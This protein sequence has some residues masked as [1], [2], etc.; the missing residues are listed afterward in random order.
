MEILTTY[1]V[2]LLL[3]GI[4]IGCGILGFFS[5]FT[6]KF[7]S[8]ASWAL[9]S[10]LASHIYPYLKPWVS[11]FISNPIGATATTLISVFLVLLV[12]FKI[13]TGHISRFVKN[14][15]LGGLDRGLGVILGLC[16]GGALLAGVALVYRFFFNVE[17]LPSALQASKLW[18]ESWN[19]SY[20]LERAL[21]FK[22]SE[23]PRRDLFDQT[24][25]GFKN[26]ITPS[27]PPKEGPRPKAS[28]P[29]SHADRKLLSKK[30]L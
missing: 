20:Y 6:E 25:L 30:A 2:D 27:L 22:I 9:A 10:L 21:P 14:S 16:T 13:A 7:F 3:I 23:R 8:L 18:R 15:P 17:P 11:G 4:V 5:G 24:S 12:T 29:Y 1:G 26:L 19:A 28:T